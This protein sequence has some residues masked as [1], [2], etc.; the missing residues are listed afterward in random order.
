MGAPAF[1]FFLVRGHSFFEPQGNDGVL[2]DELSKND[3][4]E[5]MRDGRI[6][7]SVRGREGPDLFG[8]RVRGACGP[9]GLPAVDHKI[10][11]VI[12]NINL[13]PLI[14]PPVLIAAESKI[15]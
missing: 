3:V 11:R 1:G 8:L 15:P 4:P 6:K 9:G 7:K 12:I 13:R 5:L 14:R 10:I 2:S